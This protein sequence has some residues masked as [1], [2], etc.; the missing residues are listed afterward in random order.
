MYALIHKYTDKILH[1]D[2]MINQDNCMEYIATMDGDIPLIHPTP[3]NFKDMIEGAYPKF[4]HSFQYPYL[5]D[6]DLNDFEIRV[7]FLS[8]SEL[9][10][11]QDSC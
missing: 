6:I 7:L 3:S 4:Q 10:N 8:Y 5:D 1:V 2:V 11:H 9:A